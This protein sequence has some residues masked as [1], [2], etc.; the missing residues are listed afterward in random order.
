MSPEDK[1]QLGIARL[2]NKRVALDT[3]NAGLISFVEKELR[4]E[5][6]YRRLTPKQKAATYRVLKAHDC[7]M[8]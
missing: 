7:V 1:L 8:T 6:I 5:M 3:Y 2:R 4:K